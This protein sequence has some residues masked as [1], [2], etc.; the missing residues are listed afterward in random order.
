[1]K[2]RSPNHTLLWTLG[3]SLG[4][5]L[6]VLTLRFAAPETFNR[7]FED[8][9]LEV[10]LVNARSNERPTEA[11]ALAQ[12]SLA[13]GGNVTEVRMSSSPLPAAVT[14]EPGTDIGEMQRKIE[15]LKVQQ[16]RLL[17]QLK[18]ELADLSRD[19]SADKSNTPEQQAR[20]ERKQQLSRQLAQIERRVEQSQGAP[21]KRYISPATKETVY[22]L[23][24]D[25][26]RRT[27]ETQ[28]TLNF[29]QVRGEKLYGKLTMVITVNSQGEL[30]ETE[31]AS[32]SRNPLL[33]ERAL[34]IV[35][36]SGPF[37]P[38]GAKM[39]RQAD[40][41]VVVSRFMFSRDDTLSTRMLAPDQ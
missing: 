1:M 23:Y 29:P 40:Q 7:V 2:R 35:R 24:Y 36:S 13:G 16:M 21:R 12:V 41:I 20:Q 27:I 30:L 14:T 25:K 31:V 28:G 5:H 3:V 22:A 18:A 9:P 32:S 39:R 4:L 19:D 26:L 17:T 8:T 10:V 38:F 34:A 37:E 33:D 11:K 6:A 15:A